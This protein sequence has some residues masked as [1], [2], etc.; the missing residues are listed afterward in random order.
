MHPSHRDAIDDVNFCKFNVY[1]ED[2]YNLEVAFM[3][4]DSFFYLYKS[5]VLHILDEVP[6]VF[7]FSN[8]YKLHRA[9]FRIDGGSG[10][11]FHHEG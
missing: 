7:A 10:T 4:L 3:Q 9:T 6:F 2:I 8:E 1:R 11:A 5:N